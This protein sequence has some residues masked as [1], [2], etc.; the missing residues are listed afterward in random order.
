MLTLSRDLISVP[1]PPR[2][3]PIVTPVAPAFGRAFDAESQRRNDG[4][5]QALHD[6]T[7]ALVE[8]L[9][10]DGVPPERVVVALKS[11]IA[12]YSSLHWTPTLIDEV[13]DPGSDHGAETY[14]KV[15]GWCLDAYFGPPTVR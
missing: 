4:T 13:E 12:R 8:R 7:I 9:K 14:R 3:T 15:F 1:S 11:A 2:F 6:A 10:R 5:E